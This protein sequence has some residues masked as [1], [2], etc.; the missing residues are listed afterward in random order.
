MHISMYSYTY[1]IPHDDKHTY[2][3]SIY[4]CIHIYTYTYIVYIYTY[5][6]IYTYT[7][8]CIYIYPYTYI[9]PHNH[10]LIRNRHADFLRSHLQKS[11]TKTRL[12]CKKDPIVATPQPTPHS[13]VCIKTVIHIWN[14]HSH[15]VFSHM[16]VTHTHELSHELSRISQVCE[17]EI[18]RCRNEMQV[19]RN[20]FFNI[21]NPNFP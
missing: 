11:P 3:R 20:L 1:I 21:C 2:L 7:Y 19:M 13:E 15:L 12:L 6:H 10:V 14:T 16:L 9:I 4:T 17:S 8:I 5:I 18:Q